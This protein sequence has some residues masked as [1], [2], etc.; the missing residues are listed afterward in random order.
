MGGVPG[1]FSCYLALRGVKTLHL[2]MREHEK[3]AFE[4]AKF[5]NSSPHVERVIYPGFE[6]HPQHELAKKQMSGF[7]GM[8]TFFINGN[9][10][11]AK[12][13][14]RNTKLFTLAESL[15]GYESLAEHPAL[16]TH[17]SVPPDQRVVLGISDT[18]VS[19]DYLLDMYSIYTC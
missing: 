5:L 11:T 2:R 14:F 16:M 15:G 10:E 1:P 13:F 12:K 7:G 4:V 19:Y 8:I 18:L 3:N 9:L 6:S 17:A